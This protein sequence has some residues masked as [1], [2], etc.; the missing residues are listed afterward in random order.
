MM[1]NIRVYYFA[2]EMKFDVSYI[3]Q[4]QNIIQEN[5]M[6]MKTKEE[7]KVQ[8]HVDKESSENLFVNWEF[9]LGSCS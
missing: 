5:W 7:Y 6:A 9:I 4:L 2:R 8:C 3:N 1:K